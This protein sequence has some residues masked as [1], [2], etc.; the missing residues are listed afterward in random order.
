MAKWWLTLVAAALVLGL[1]PAPNGALESLR[2]VRFPV[3]LPLNE[4]VIRIPMTR[5]RASG[6]EP[7]TLEATLYLPDG[8]GPFPLVVL[9]HGTPRDQSLRVS[10]KRLGY[11]VQSWEFVTMGFAVVIPMRRGYGDSGG[12]YAEEEGLCDRAL[13]YEAGLESAQDLL[14]TVRFMSAKPFIDR[15]KIILVGHSTGGFAS[16]A[17]AS[18][19]FPGLLGVINFSGGRGSTKEKNC[20]PPNLVEA[21]RR[22]GATT[23]VPTLWIYAEND[24]YFPP[25]LARQL[26]QAYLDAGGQARLVM[27]PPFEAEG[28]FLFSDG[29][30]LALWT[31]IVS[32]FLSQPGF[33][34]PGGAVK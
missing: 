28:H 7:L 23:R 19:G 20:S 30:G 2:P 29:R 5:T 17:L 31:P 4:Q 6:P 15:G 18:Q 10:Q 11:P 13:F 9:S 1:L 22:F 32:R 16:L 14:A 33:R 25:W 3:I 27:L 12:D 21:F 26:H 8:A 34:L 24:T